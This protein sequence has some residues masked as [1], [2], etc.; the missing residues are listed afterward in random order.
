MLYL[1]ILNTKGGHLQF[2]SALRTTKSIAELRTKKSCGTAI[3]DF[4]NLTSAI[5]QLSAVSCQFRYFIV[6][7]PQLKMVLKINHKYFY[8]CLFL[9]KPKTCPK[10][11]VAQEFW[12]P[13]FFLMNLPD[14]M[15]KNMLK[16]ATKVRTWSCRS[17]KK[18]QL[19]DC[20]VAVADRHFFKKLRNCLP[21]ICGIAIADSKKGSTCSPLLNTAYFKSHETKW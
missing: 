6:V 2:K 8:N 18:M 21:S 12:P 5:P 16:I 1:T 14:F 10:G 7:F 17:Q 15:A 3:V 11:T 20:G 13:I 4:Q 9:W 19:R